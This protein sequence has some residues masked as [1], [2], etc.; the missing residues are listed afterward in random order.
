MKGPCTEACKG[1]TRDEGV[2]SRQGLWLWE[3]SLFPGL[4]GQGEAEVM[5][6]PGV[7][8]SLS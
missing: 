2:G 7:A 4:T 5:P 6:E 1:R 3:L 8:N